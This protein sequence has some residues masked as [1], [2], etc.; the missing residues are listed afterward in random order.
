VNLGFTA[1]LPRIQNGAAGIDRIALIGVDAAVMLMIED[2]ANT[3]RFVNSQH[4]IHTPR[5]VIV[6]QHDAALGRLRQSAVALDKR[7]RAASRSP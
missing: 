2:A 4:V 6:F 3:G 7:A 5:S 1:A